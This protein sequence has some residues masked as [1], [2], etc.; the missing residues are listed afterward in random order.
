MKLFLICMFKN[1]NFA[2]NFTNF[3]EN[4]KKKNKL[5]GVHGVFFSSSLGEQE[6]GAGLG[7]GAAAYKISLK[8][9][10]TILTQN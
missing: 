5:C 4:L 9:F 6:G 7:A 10:K 2:E 8:V 1:L 3:A